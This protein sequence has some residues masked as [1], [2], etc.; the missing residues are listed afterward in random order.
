MRVK[1]QQRDGQAIVRGQLF[2]RRLRLQ[3]AAACVGNV[4]QDRGLYLGVALHAVYQVRNQ[5]CP[6]LQVDVDLRGRRV[7]LVA[8]HRH[9]VARGHVAAA[10]QQ[11]TQQQY[12]HDHN[13]SCIALAHAGT[14]VPIQHLCHV[15]CSSFRS[16]FTNRRRHHHRRCRRRH[17][18][19]SRRRSRRHRRSPRRRPPPEST[20]TVAAARGRHPSSHPGSARAKI[21]RHR[22]CPPRPPPPLL[23][24]MMYMMAKKISRP[25]MP[26][27]PLPRPAAAPAWLLHRLQRHAGVLRNDLRNIVDAGPHR[28]VVVAGLQ[29]RHHLPANVAGLGIG[30]NAL[31]P[32]TRS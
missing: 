23:R 2:V 29:V 1:R 13:D 28:A 31:H 19:Q 9:G 5:V 7:H 22:P 21:R 10:D 32:I 27:P 24:R 3:Q 6:A 30:Q 26:L 14:S 16:N 17:H 25:T 4:G 15:V 11:R 12:D 8:L 20:S 18:R